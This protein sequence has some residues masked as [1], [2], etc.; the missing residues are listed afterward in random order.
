M[1]K[2]IPLTD[3]QVKSLLG[4]DGTLTI[5]KNQKKAFLA[6]LTGQ[7]ELLREDWNNPEVIFDSKLARKVTLIGIK[8]IQVLGEDGVPDPKHITNVSALLDQRG[9][10]GFT[11][12][13]KNIKASV[14]RLRWQKVQTLDPKAPGYNTVPERLER[15]FPGSGKGFKGHIHH[16]LPIYVLGSLFLKILLTRET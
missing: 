2:T 9:S 4:E 1:A 14:N 6:W 11:S 8:K 5:P 3:D 15:L 16:R 10:I 7:F 13:V 12:I